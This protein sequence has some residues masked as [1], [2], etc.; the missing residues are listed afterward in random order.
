MWAVRHMEAILEVVARRHHVVLAR[1][2]LEAG[3]LLLVC[4]VDDAVDDA[5][6]NFDLVEL[7]VPLH[8]VHG[9]LLLLQGNEANGIGGAVVDDLAEDL[10]EWHL[11]VADVE[12]DD[13]HSGHVAV[14]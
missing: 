2:L 14:A 1:V 5:A 3:L 11:L 7:H 13:L 6:V 12:G 4:L 8:A 10:A 9:A